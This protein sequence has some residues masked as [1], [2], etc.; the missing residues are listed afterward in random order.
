[1]RRHALTLT[2]ALGLTVCLILTVIDPILWAHDEPLHTL[3]LSW[4]ALDISAAQLLGWAVTHRQ[5]KD[6][7]PTDSHDR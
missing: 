2:A 1:V 3:I 6:Q 4:L 7:A 5:V